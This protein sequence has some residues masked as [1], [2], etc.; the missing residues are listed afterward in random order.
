MNLKNLNIKELL[1]FIF[2]LFVSSILIFNSL[3]SIKASITM[4]SIYDKRKYQ[5]QKQ[6][7]QIIKKMNELDYVTSPFY[8][9]QQL[10]NSL[11]YYKPG[12]KVVIF[13]KPVEELPTPTPSKKPE[14]IELWKK[15]FGIN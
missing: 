14:P 15:V 4:I 3:K 6:Y 2:V 1:G 5:L 8:V 11:N 10:R 9:E 7:I 12:E 13:T